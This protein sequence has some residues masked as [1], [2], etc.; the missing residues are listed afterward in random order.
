MKQDTIVN[1]WKGG[2]QNEMAKVTGQGYRAILS[3]CWYLNYISYGPD[4]PNVSKRFINKIQGLRRACGFIRGFKL[5]LSCIF[6]PLLSFFDI[7]FIIP[8][9]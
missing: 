6:K 5:K 7:I 8:N 3:S 2:W 1:V 9:L 4:W